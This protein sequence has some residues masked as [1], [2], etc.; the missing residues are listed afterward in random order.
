MTSTFLIYVPSLQ[1]TS[2]ELWWLSGGCG[3][4]VRTVLCCV[5]YD[6]CI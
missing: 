2:S 6:S 3:K 1:R 5:V 4:I